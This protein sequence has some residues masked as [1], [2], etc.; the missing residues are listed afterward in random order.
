M[1]QARA[2]S[3]FTIRPSVGCSQVQNVAG[4]VGPPLAFGFREKAEIPWT[5]KYTGN[6]PKRQ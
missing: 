2:S 3:S 6:D 5:A 4:A 1:A